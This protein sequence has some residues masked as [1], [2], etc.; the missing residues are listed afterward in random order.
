MAYDNT[1]LLS[2]TESLYDY[3]KLWLSVLTGALPYTTSNVARWFI[4]MENKQSTANR[5]T[6]SIAGRSNC[7]S[8]A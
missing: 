1:H 6:C 3:H 7:H 2:A 4:G 5:C 8:S